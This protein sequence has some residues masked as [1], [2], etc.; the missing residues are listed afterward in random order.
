VEAGEPGFRDAR[1]TRGDHNG[2]RDHVFPC[3]RFIEIAY[4]KST[5]ILSRHL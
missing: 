4:R 5:R 1:R 3:L 2:D